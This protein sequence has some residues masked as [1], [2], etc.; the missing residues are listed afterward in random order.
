MNHVMYMLLI[1]AAGVCW[2]LQA[3]VNAKL[4]AHADQPMVAVLVNGGGAAVLAGLAMLVLGV[5]AGRMHVPTAQAMG[6]AP[7]WAYL[8]GVFSVLVIVAQSTS[9]VPLG[10]ALLITLFVAG[11]GLSGL[12]FDQFGWLSFERKPVTGTRIAGVACLLLGAVLLSAG[13]RSGAATPAG[14]ET[15]AGGDAA[16][17]RAV[18]T[19]PVDGNG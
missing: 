16:T 17:H 5:A 18:R 3:A 13:Q 2:P 10:A 7:W 15:V 12:L 1:F 14:E 8:G 6:S 11:Q 4:K 19:R 9:A